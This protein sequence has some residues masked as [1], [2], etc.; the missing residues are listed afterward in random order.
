[1]S[2]KIVKTVHRVKTVNTLF[3]LWGRLGLRFKPIYKD[4]IPMKAYTYAYLSGR[5]SSNLTFSHKLL[6]KLRLDCYA[7]WVFVAPACV[8]AE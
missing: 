3:N 6:T 1:L 2:D 8:G 7:L 5:I 4:A